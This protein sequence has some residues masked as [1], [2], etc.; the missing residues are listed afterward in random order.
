[1]ELITWTTCSPVGILEKERV[2]LAAE[3]G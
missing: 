1:M 2:R 3:R